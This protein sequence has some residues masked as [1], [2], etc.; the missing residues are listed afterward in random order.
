MRSEVRRPRLQRAVRRRR[1]AVRQ[2]A[3]RQRRPRPHRRTPKRHARTPKS[4]HAREARAGRGRPWQPRS[5]PSVPSAPRG[6]PCCPRPGL[7]AAPAAWRAEAWVRARDPPATVRGRPPGGRRPCEEGD[8]DP[9]TAS[10]FGKVKARHSHRKLQISP[11]VVELYSIRYRS[12]P[13]S[14]VR[15]PTAR[16]SSQCLSA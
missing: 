2:R 6:P 7:A 14:G 12:K 4:W 9:H 11:M 15:G 8:R 16:R 10:K 13:A 1:A 5:R 3:V